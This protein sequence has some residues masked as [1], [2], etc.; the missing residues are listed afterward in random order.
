V[1]TPNNLYVVRTPNNLYV[2]RTPNNLLITI[3]LQIYYLQLN[4]LLLV[5]S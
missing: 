3:N 5:R 4:N 2:V 1:R